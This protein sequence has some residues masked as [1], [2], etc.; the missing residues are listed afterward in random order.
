MMHKRNKW[1]LGGGLIA[2]VFL[3]L[4]TLT[5]KN[6]SV[7]FYTTG[8]ALAQAATLQGKKV[9][10]GG[11]VKPGTYQRG[12]GDEPL[13][14]TLSDLETGDIEVSY[15]GTPPDMFQEQRGAIVEGYLDPEHR[16]FI[17]QSLMVKHSEEYKTPK[18]GASID[19]ELVYKSIFKGSTEEK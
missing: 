7:Y 9:R 3:A 10:I 4:S 12:E 8:E 19:K 18:H 11:M 6:N 2:V 5:L 16:T 13:R 14:F 17:A 1:I 15:R